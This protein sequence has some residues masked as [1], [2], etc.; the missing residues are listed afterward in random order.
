MKA[1]RNPSL[2]LEGEGQASADVEGA[3]KG[4]DGA[5]RGSGAPLTVDNVAAATSGLTI[6]SAQSDKVKEDEDEIR[7]QAGLAIR[8]KPEFRLEDFEEE[9]GA[10]AV[11]TDR[12]GEAGSAAGSGSVGGGAKERLE[13]LMRG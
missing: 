12:P 2:K 11:G 6:P 4:V 7:S 8:T 3:A 1:E 10:T 5:R 13:A 9:E